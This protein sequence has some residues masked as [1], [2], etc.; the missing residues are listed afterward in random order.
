MAGSLQ[1]A[2]RAGGKRPRDLHHKDRRRALAGRALTLA[3]IKRDTLAGLYRN[4]P[5]VA[6]WSGTAHGVLQAVSTYDQHQATVRGGSRAE[7]NSLKT[8]TGD[9][10]RLDRSTWK[11]LTAVLEQPLPALTA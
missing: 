2:R 9:F 11:T 5:R 7:R 3:S 4:D 8:I 6:P 1:P 10:G